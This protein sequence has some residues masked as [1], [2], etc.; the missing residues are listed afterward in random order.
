M[1]NEAKENISLYKALIHNTDV[2]SNKSEAE[3]TSILN[4]NIQGG[5]NK[6]DTALEDHKVTSSK[7]KNKEEDLV[8]KMIENCDLEEP[9]LGK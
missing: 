2:K 8:L 9:V 7:D 5:L 1:D 3:Q 6:L 4:D